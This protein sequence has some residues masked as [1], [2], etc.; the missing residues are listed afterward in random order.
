MV[1]EFPELQGVMGQYYAEADGELPGVAAA[2]GEH[3]R[4]RFAGDVLP[5]SPPGMALAIAD[6]LDTL[7]GIF[8]LNK[9]PTGSRDPF[10]L[11]RAAV[12]LVRTIVENDLELNLED[13]IAKAVKAQPVNVA[14]CSALASSIYEFIIE[15]MRAWYLERPEI[16][17]EVFESV[18]VRRPA[19]LLDFHRRLQAVAAFSRL[20]EAGSLAAANKRIGNI[21]RQAGGAAAAKLEPGL[22]T[23]AAEIELHAALVAATQSVAPLLANHEY[24]EALSQLAALRAPVDRFFDVVMVM[25]DD[26]ALQKNRLAL[27][28]ALRALFLDVADISLLSLTQ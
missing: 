17:A 24:T 12:G 5:G 2:I 20:E 21:L 16:G 15:R 25:A 11:R 18:R 22:L 1:G 27:L 6:K 13:L 9:K 8:A 23:D 3:Y 10:G 4:P 26:P 28:A 7:A 14:D 19:S